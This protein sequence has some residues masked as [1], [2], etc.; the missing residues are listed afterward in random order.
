M[1]WRDINSAMWWIFGSIA[2]SPF[3]QSYFHL[4][5]KKLYQFSDSSCRFGQRVISVQDMIV[6][7]KEVESGGSA[8]NMFEVIYANGTKTQYVCPNAAEMRKWATLLSLALMSTVYNDVAVSCSVCVGEKAILVA[9]EGLHCAVDGFMRLLL[10]IDLAHVLQATGVFA[11]ERFACVLKG[12]NKLD[13]F[14]FRT[15]DEVDRLLKLLSRLG[16]PEINAE[17][18]GSSRLSALLN[19]MPRTDDIFY[20]AANLSDTAYENVEA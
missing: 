13:W 19:S 1:Y 6:D 16:V 10:R 3:V 4:E 9:Q 2:P 11:M 20:F 18:G 17:E 15:A 5:N 14:F 7:I 12:D 8:P